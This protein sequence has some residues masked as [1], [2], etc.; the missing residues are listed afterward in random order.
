M[1]MKIAGAIFVI[2]VVIYYIMNQ[3]TTIRSK[4][5]VR[6]F[7]RPMVFVILVIALVIRLIGWLMNR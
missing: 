6:R 4:Q 3:Q 5:Q 2:F 1:G 7:A